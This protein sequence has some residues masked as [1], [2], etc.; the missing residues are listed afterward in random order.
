[1]LIAASYFWSFSANVFM[2]G[3]GPMTPTLAD[4]HMLIG[5]RI[6]GSTKPYDFLGK[7]SKKLGKICSKWPS[8]IDEFKKDS[9]SVDGKVHI[10][11]LNMWLDRYAFCGQACSPIFNYQVLAEKITVD[12]EVPLGKYLLDTLYYLLNLVSQHL[13]KNEI[14]PTITGSWWLL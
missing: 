8:Y 10:A 6:I 4:I 13:M 14:V 11:F 12:Y 5:L 7:W 1:M 3:Y 2:F 9:S